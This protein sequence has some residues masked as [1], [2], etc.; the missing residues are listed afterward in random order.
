MQCVAALALLAACKGKNSPTGPAQVT[1]RDGLVP[2]TLGQILDFAGSQAASSGPLAPSQVYDDFMFTGAGTIRTVA[3]QGGYCTPTTNAAAPTPSATAF[4]VGI[5]ADVSGRPN[6]AEPLSIATYPLAQVAE[7][8]D[9][10]IVGLTCTDGATR[11]GTNV[12][13]GTYRYQLTLATPFSAAANTRYWF[14]VQA[15][16]PTYYPL[17]GWRDGVN[18]NQTSLNYSNNTFQRTATFDRAFSLKP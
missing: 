16:S 7:T 11:S 2:S 5:Y 1:S 13:Y 15:V 9:R 3:W 4:R 12:T 17:W 14:S 6:L 10:T 18:D 8:L